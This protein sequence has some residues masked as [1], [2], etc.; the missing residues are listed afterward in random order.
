MC[1]KYMLDKPPVF[2]VF[3]ALPA[4]HEQ[5]H[6]KAPKLSPQYFI[7][8]ELWSFGH[9]K[10]L[11]VGLTHDCTLVSGVHGQLNDRNMTKSSPLHHRA[12]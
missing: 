6:E 12:S 8:A 9:G 2:P 10:A 3:W 1:S 4:A 7:H 11:A 5:T